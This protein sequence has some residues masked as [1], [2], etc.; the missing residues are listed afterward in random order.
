MGMDI[1]VPAGTSMLVFPEPGSGVLRG[2]MSSS[3]VCRGIDKTAVDQ[4]VHAQ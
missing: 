2:M 3:T 4:T 1:V